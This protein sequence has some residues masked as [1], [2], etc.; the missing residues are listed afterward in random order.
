[1]FKIL[2]ANRYYSNRGGDS[3]YTFELTQ[4]LQSHGHSVIPFAMNDEMRNERSEY[5]G[6]FVDNIDFVESLKKA[7]ILLGFRVISR[8][9]YSKH[10]RQKINMLISETNPGIA[11]LQTIHHHISPSILYEFKKYRIPVVWTI[12]DYALV[13]PAT[14]FLSKGKICEACL[15]K[16]FYMAVLKNCKYDSLKASLVAAMETYFHH[17]LNILKM[18]DVLIAPSKFVQEKL[19]LHGVDKD[20]VIHIP[21]CINTKSFIPNYTCGNYAVFLGRLAREKGVSV[22]LHAMKKIPD[23]KLLIIGIGPFE[24][25]L[26]NEARINNLSNVI[27]LGYRN[28]EEIISIVRNAA[29]VVVPSEWYENL[30]MSIMEAL[31]LGKPVVA[32]RIGGIQEMIKE[33]V[34]GLMFN[35]GD[36]KDLAEKMLYLWNHPKMIEEM[37]FQGRRFVEERY[38]EEQHYQAIM[39]VYL[40][41]T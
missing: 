14:L 31:A 41:L 30:P 8:T 12:H 7:N 35:M 1:M 36:D 15:G 25:E 38:S 19:I 28:R 17:A 40:K 2:I 33:G 22:L 29:F 4:L 18:V 13:C 23:R 6:Y 32:S 21:N 10:A 9:F 37:G 27:F 16:K 5:S 34:N 20:K 39:Q 24:E 11:H 3:V 26:R